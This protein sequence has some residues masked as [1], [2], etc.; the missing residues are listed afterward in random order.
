MGWQRSS[1]NP[2]LRL[3]EHNVLLVL[4]LLFKSRVFQFMLVNTCE[5]GQNSL[6]FAQVRRE[7]LILTGCN[8][9]LL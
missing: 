9:G 2:Y 6:L 3:K 5:Y 7:I 4:S 8:E 1:T